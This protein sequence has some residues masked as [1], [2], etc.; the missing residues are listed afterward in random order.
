MRRLVEWLDRSP[1]WVHTGWC[2][3][4]R[5]RGQDGQLLSGQCS[6][7][8]TAKGYGCTTAATGLEGAL[9]NIIP[10]QTDIRVSEQLSHLLTNTHCLLKQINHVSSSFQSCVRP[11][12]LA[13]RTDVS[14]QDAQTGISI[15]QV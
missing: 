1:L 5:P 14:S 4:G 7:R 13:N 12:A 2:H 3:E 8:L 11:P 15:L 6:S 10:L 9:F